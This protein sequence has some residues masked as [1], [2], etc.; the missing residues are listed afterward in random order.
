[1]FAGM[2]RSAKL[3]EK[4]I[5]ASKAFRLTKAARFGIVVTAILSFLIFSIS[6]YSTE[7][8]NFTFAV[9][10]RAYEIGVT[11][12]E[13]ADEKIYTSRLL[14][15]QVDNADGMT[16]LCGIMP[17]REPD[18]PT[19]IPPDETYFDAEGSNNGENYIAYSFY[20]EMT[21]QGIFIADLVAEI[22][23]IGASRGAEEAV[24][25]KVIF[26]EVSTVYAKL[27][28]EN[29][30][31][32]GELEP[33]TDQAFFGPSTIMRQT[34]ND[35]SPG[36]MMKVTVIVWYEGYDSDHNIGIWNGGVK[37][38]MRFTVSNVTRIDEEEETTE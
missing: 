20:V 17:D 10:Q 29:G 30:D 8:G 16:D 5:F 28:S 31:N 37:M 19:C 9:D 24:R 2:A 14:A 26:D 1:M 35:F 22:D 23:I 18:H 36:D 27:Q 7:S 32:P 4:V 34:F 11:L 38:A 12:Y 21:G 25:V 3:A 6:F 15:E 33:Y 13:H